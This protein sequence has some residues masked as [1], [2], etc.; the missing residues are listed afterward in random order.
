MSQDQQEREFVEKVGLF[1][2]SSGMP[3]MA[4]RLVGLLL[5]CD[6]PA[7]S[8][9]QLAAALSA[10]KGSISTNTRLLMAGGLIEKVAM[11]G[12]RGTYFR[13]RT[14]AWEQIIEEQVAAVSAFRQLLD[15]GIAMIPDPTRRQRLE[16]ARE[17]YTFMEQEFPLILAHWRQRRSN[18]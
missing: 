18:S 8:S 16:D 13:V 10:S 2:E 11:P 15:S 1:M 7:L 17:F 9:A 5:I 4:G 6:P 14:N 3:R 12:E